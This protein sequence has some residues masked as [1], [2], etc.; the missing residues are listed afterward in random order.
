V[1]IAFA[2]VLKPVTDPRQLARL[3]RSL[4][5]LADVEV[6]IL[7]HRA[8]DCPTA[9]RDTV[10][11]NVFLHP[12]F[13]FPRL[14]GARAL[15][16]LTLARKLLEIKPNILIIGTAEL[17]PVGLWWHRRTGG[18]LV[19]DVRENYA[20]NLRT[21]RIF[22]AFVARPLAWLMARL[23]ARAAP[24][25]AAVWLAERVYAA[26]LPWLA[27][28]TGYV[29]IIENKYQPAS[30]P[31]AARPV[32]TVGQPLNLLLSGTL[33]ALYGTFDVIAAVAAAQ[34]ALTAGDA[35]PLVNLWLV[36]HAPRA[37]DAQ[38]LRALAAQ[39]AWLHLTGIEAPVPHTV[40]VDAIR[41]ADC[42]VLP[43]RTHPSLDGCIPSKLWEYLGESLPILAPADAAWL[44][45]LAM[46]VPS[47]Q[48]YQ[49][50]N[51]GV[52]LARIARQLSQNQAQNQASPP[53]S[54][55]FWPPEG[56]RAQA[57]I[58]QLSQKWA[59]FEKTNS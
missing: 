26:Q 55:A 12:V 25:L 44:S 23:E 10:C 13:A 19:Y 3:G 15:A 9:R 59:L 48:R 43:Y 14:S 4:A 22:P 11:L 32:R 47:I 21:Q 36:G 37:A 40:I 2:S 30:L 45:S 33:N 35:S 54:V 29:E 57:V 1:R 58:L 20:L 27:R 16:N 5:E 24:H 52:E 53:P 18:Q 49:R 50:P 8:A 56:A 38:H 17:L 6:H 42:G 31:P 34:V 46:E 51:L 39:Y 41:R 28:C 7:A